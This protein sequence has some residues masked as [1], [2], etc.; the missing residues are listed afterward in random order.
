[1]QLGS[2]VALLLSC[3]FYE[4][5]S[6]IIGCL[7]DWEAGPW[8]DFVPPV[9]PRGLSKVSRNQ[10]AE[11]EHGVL[12]CTFTGSCCKDTVII[13]VVFAGGTTCV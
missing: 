7:K 10:H 3:L 13:L 9:Y 11:V 1:M 5:N 8:A 12:F 6:K 4:T 2:I